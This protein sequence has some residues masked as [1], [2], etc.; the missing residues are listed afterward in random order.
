[1]IIVYRIAPHEVYQKNLKNS[2]NYTLIRNKKH[3]F[4]KIIKKSQ[5]QAYC[6]LIMREGLISNF[7]TMPC[8]FSTLPFHIGYI[9][10][11]KN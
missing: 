8:N 3:F 10:N 6:F 7:E 1:M 2:F 9:F 4:W 11:A 5:L